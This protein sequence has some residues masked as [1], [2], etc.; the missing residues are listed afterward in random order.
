MTNAQQ[1]CT[2]GIVVLRANCAGEVGKNRLVTKGVGNRHRADTFFLYNFWTSLDVFFFFFFVS[3]LLLNW[4]FFFFFGDTTMLL[5]AAIHGSA[6]EWSFGEKILSYLS[7]H[8]YK[9]RAY[10]P[11]YLSEVKEQKG[12]IDSPYKMWFKLSSA[13]RSRPHYWVNPPAHSPADRLAIHLIIV[14]SLSLSNYYKE[15]L[16][17]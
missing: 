16:F 2:T 17:L 4:L 1:A 3:L 14:W 7:L 11:L 12:P 13:S 9:N 15:D 6:W 8:I 10:G 5:G